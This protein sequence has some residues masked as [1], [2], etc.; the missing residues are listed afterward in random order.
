MK[1]FAQNH[2][3]EILWTMLILALTLISLSFF[4]F[5]TFCA[6]QERE[7]STEMLYRVGI[8][9]TA[10]NLKN[11]LEA[12]DGRSSYHYAA[13]AAEQAS[14]AGDHDTA[15]MFRRMA[16]LL[17]G[18]AVADSTILNA[19][20]QYLLKGEAVEL[21]T[22]TEAS[23]STMP[24]VGFMNDKDV[25]PVSSYNVE[26]AKKC[27]DSV[28]G[29]HNTLRRGMKSKNGELV[30]S[31]SNAYAVIDA[32]TGVPIELAIS[33][34]PAEIKLNADECVSSALDFLTEYFPMDIVNSADLRRIEADDVAGT[35][36]ICCVSKG[37]RFT[38]SVRRDTGRVARFI[39][40]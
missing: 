28:F 39:V 37:R 8:S 7:E 18:D 16:D 14:V 31:C 5:F 2:A 1:K 27:L 4:V 20:E 33:L 25:H 35:F 32:R 13:S 23:E 21:E 40:G 3:V 12:D 17:L 6:E 36:E 11:A 19:V 10:E 29:N 24:G 22:M 26:N 15:V 9:N 34:S 30:F 38:M